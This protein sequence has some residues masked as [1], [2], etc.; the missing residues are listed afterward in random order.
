MCTLK[1]H[2]TRQDLLRETNNETSLDKC[3]LGT[4]FDLPV[5]HWRHRQRWRSTKTT[6]VSTTRKQMP[7]MHSIYVLTTQNQSKL[8]QTRGAKDV[9]P[10][11][12]RTEVAE[13]AEKCRFFVPV[14]LTFDLQTCQTEGPNKPSVWIWRKSVQGFRR[15]FIHKQ[16]TTDWRR[17]KH[18]LPQSTACSNKHETTKIQL[19]FEHTQYLV[20]LWYRLIKWHL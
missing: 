6:V 10:N 20:H 11:V 16:K 15:Y 3:R 12:N 19:L 7:N 17:Q 4:D 2:C 8:E 13:R 18:N 1:Q 9:L 14:V 5:K